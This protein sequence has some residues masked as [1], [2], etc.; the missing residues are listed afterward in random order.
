MLLSVSSM[1]VVIL[2]SDF[3]VV[4]TESVLVSSSQPEKRNDADRKIASKDIG[5]RFIRVPPN[6]SLYLNYIKVVVSFSGQ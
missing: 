5:L 2:V 6:C 1:L 4:D 3:V